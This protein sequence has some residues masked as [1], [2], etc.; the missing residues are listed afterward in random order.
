MKVNIVGAGLAGSE[1]AFQL[2][3]RGIEVNL[4]EMRPLKQTP[5]HKTEKFAELVCSNS[6]RAIDPTHPAGILKKELLELNSLLIH[7][8]LKYSIPGGGALVVDRK[9]FSN[10]I[11]Q[12][13]K[14]QPNITILNEEIKKLNKL[15][16]ITI[17][18]TGPLTEKPLA[19]ELI[20][21]TGKDNFYFFDAIAP[22]VDADSIDMN[23]AFY[24][25]RY[26]DNKDYINCPLTKEEYFKF[27]NELK[28]AKTFPLKE[29]EKEIHF[30]GCMPIEEM[31]RRGEMTLAFGPMKPVGL[32]DP[33]TGKQ[34]FA[35]VQL[36]KE[37][38]EGTAYN[39]VGFQTKM[40]INEQERVFKLI[41]ALKNARFLRYGSMHK[42]IYL[43]APEVL[44]DDMSLKNKPEIFIAGQLSGVEG[45]I[46]S[47]AHGLLVSLIVLFKIKGIKFSYPNNTFAIGALYSFLREKRKNFQPSNINFSLFSYPNEF[48]KIKNKKFKKKKISEFAYKNFL[49][50]KS[51]IY[52]SLQ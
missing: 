13:L 6:L 44:N 28:K 38:K 41:P 47:I 2:A 8:A 5:A 19:D 15:E 46:E 9:K 32:I 24:G 31:A 45:Y 11:T 26:S 36:R 43:N 1:A 52:N 34:P 12:I 7:T 18:A 17:I 51:L 48:R 25:S 20:R 14:S 37:N 22:I 21:I 50:W 10:E 23:K 49:D 16:G 35:V 30:E 29:F 39:L 27:I 4:Y 42:N 40:L 3:I 33:R